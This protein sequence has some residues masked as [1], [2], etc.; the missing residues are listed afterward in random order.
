MTDVSPFWDPG[1]ESGQYVCWCEVGL[2]QTRFGESLMYQTLMLTCVL[3]I[4]AAVSQN[5]S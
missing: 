3:H 2:V 1:F 5:V 4:D